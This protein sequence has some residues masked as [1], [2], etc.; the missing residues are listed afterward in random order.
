MVLVLL[1]LYLHTSSLPISGGSTLGLGE[2]P[3]PQIQMLAD[4]SDVISEVQKCSKIQIFRGSRTP[5]GKL[6]AL[7]QTPNLWGG[8]HFPRQEHLTPLSALLASF[9]W[10]SGPNP[11]QSWQPYRFQ[12]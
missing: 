7:P 3:P 2:V 6:T 9:L 10:V 8:A 11:L 5:L 1:G 12:I 4:R